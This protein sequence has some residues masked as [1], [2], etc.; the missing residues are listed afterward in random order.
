[1]DSR[2]E[3]IKIWETHL[4]ILNSKIN[5]QRRLI[6]KISAGKWQAPPVSDE[7]L[8][9]LAKHDLKLLRSMLKELKLVL[10]RLNNQTDKQ[11]LAHRKMNKLRGKEQKNRPERR[12]LDN[13]DPIY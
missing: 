1:M 6:T 9:A 3:E 7:I 10:H 11:Y 5:K 13:F 8:H 2:L 4:K 12:G